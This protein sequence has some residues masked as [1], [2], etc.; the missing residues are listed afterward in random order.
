M[1]VKESAFYNSLCVRFSDSVFHLKAE[2]SREDSFNLVLSSPC[3]YMCFIRLFQLLTKSDYP[4]TVDTFKTLQ[5][6]SV[7]KMEQRI[8]NIFGY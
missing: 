3:I 4:A 6:G 8:P 2:L 7:L 5:G 1:V